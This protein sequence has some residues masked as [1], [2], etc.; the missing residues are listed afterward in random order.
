MLRRVGLECLSIAARIGP[1]PDRAPERFRLC[2]G[3]LN[4]FCQR[5]PSSKSVVSA[6]EATPAAPTLR[7]QRTNYRQLYRCRPRS[8]HRCVHAGSY[9]VRLY[10]I[11]RACSMQAVIHHSRFRIPRNKVRVQA[12]ARVRQP[13]CLCTW[14][15]KQG[16]DQKDRPLARPSEGGVHLTSAGPARPRN[17]TVC[18]DI[19]GVVKSVVGGWAALSL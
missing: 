10:G 5:F 13:A 1:P 18:S 8:P 19:G 17:F 9:Q 11:R 16:S 12:N 2:A 7:R 4:P 14:H 6:V 3:L 15:A